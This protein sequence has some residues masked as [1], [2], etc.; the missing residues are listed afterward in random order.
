MER[1]FGSAHVCDVGGHGADGGSVGGVVGEVWVKGGGDE[2]V[3]AGDAEFGHGGGE[4]VS[5]CWRWRWCRS[6]IIIRPRS[7]KK[8]KKKTC[9]RKSQLIK[10]SFAFSPS[11]ALSSPPLLGFSGAEEK[12]M[13]KETS[14]INPNRTQQAENGFTY[15][16]HHVACSFPPLSS[17]FWL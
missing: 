4:E 12:P 7:C 3:Y 13:Q 14:C 10:Y 15:L 6:I 2:D 17:L 9:R 16:G 5:E 1:V 11:A 8:T